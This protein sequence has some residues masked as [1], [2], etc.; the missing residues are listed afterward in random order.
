MKKIDQRTKAAFER[1]KNFHCDNT[2]VVSDGEVTRC[3]LFGNLI[4]EKRGDQVRYQTTG[5]DTPT[6]RNRLNACGCN[7]HIVGGWIVYC[8]DERV[9]VP[10]F[11]C[12]EDGRL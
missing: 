5:W 10:R 12:E 4:A 11:F 2:V 6:T 1:N 7:C 3:Y 9:R 8:H